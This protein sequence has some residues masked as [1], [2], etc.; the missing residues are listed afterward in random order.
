MTSW[1]L[2]LG[3]AAVAGLALTVLGLRGRRV[4]DHRLCRRCGF[5]LTGT[6]DGEICN[7]CGA[8]LT[9][10]RAVKVGHRVRRRGPLVAGLAMLVP[11]LLVAG[12]A[13]YVVLRGVDVQAYKPAWLLARELRSGDAATRDATVTE[14]ERRMTTDDLS[15]DATAGVVDWA[16]DMQADADGEWK[17]QW[18]G[19]VEMAR[20]NGKADDAQWTRF[21]EQ[22]VV[23]TFTARPTIRQGDP[24][25][26]RVEFERRLGPTVRWQ[27]HI[28]VSDVRAGDA[29]FP[30]IDP[31]TPRRGG[32][33][34]GLV[35][36]RGGYSSGFGGNAIIPGEQTETLAVG[37][38]DAT[39]RVAY[40]L[41]E[42]VQS[43]PWTQPPDSADKVATP[44]VRRTV[45]LSDD[46]TVR[47]RDEPPRF[48]T[49]DESLRAG[50]E[51]TV[52]V[53]AIRRASEADLGSGMM[54][55]E[56]PWSL[57][58]RR[59]SQ[60]GGVP[61]QYMVV[62]RRPGGAE[63]VSRASNSASNSTVGAAG[64][65]TVASGFNLPDDAVPPPGP[66]G[67]A[68]GGTVTLILRPDMDAIRKR[69]DDAPVWGR[70][71]VFEN[72]P[73]RRSEDE[74][75]GRDWQ[76]GPWQSPGGEVIDPDAGFFANRPP[77]ATRPA[78]APAAAEVR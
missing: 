48:V 49:T 61:L 16:L 2:L 52:W 22:G 74:P 71:I 3:V 29:V 66:G 37:P 45:T 4:D 5:D 41:G 27:M 17:T 18:G 53:S 28:D 51:S 44:L 54:S 7:E 23:P 67:E 63:A 31:E 35:F 8:D 50:V 32:L 19:L 72:V 70:E 76:T 10:P 9:R 6:P 38:R 65:L 11:C 21:A 13:G 1:A 59:T 43:G 42:Y 40:V 62:I 46:V 33:S 68:V 73:L 14:F 78:S 75:P 15:A 24:L 58:V 57:G 55:E 26:T 56:R 20:T 39:A 69:L 60:P 30:V 77:A 64:V 47:G 36:Q 34:G 12:L 25:P